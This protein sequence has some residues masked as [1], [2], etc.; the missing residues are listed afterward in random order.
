MPLSDAIPGS[1]SL[2]IKSAALVSNAQ[3][4][5][6]IIVGYDSS[7]RRAC[8]KVFPSRSRGGRDF[9]P[10]SINEK[11]RRGALSCPIYFEMGILNF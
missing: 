9:S 1:K 7:L 10:W 11:G 3:L 4:A 6:M 5:E 8:C 2:I